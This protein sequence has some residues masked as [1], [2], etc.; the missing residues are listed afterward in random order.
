MAPAFS[1]GTRA[2]PSLL[3]KSI[4]Q[5]DLDLD[6]GQMPEYFLLRRVPAMYID[7]IYAMMIPCIVKERKTPLIWPCGHAECSEPPTSGHF[8]GTLSCASSPEHE[9]SPRYL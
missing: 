1:L 7:A 6:D 8:Q 4:V 9:L 2:K 5:Q 3:M